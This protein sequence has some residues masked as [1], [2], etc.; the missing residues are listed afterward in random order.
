M[1]NWPAAVSTVG[2]AGIECLHDVRNGGNRLASDLKF[3]QIK[4]DHHQ[5]PL[6]EESQMA[7]GDIS[8]IRSIFEQDAPFSSRQVPTRQHGAAGPKHVA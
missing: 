3:V 4:R 2:I 5:R 6:P 8:G 1:L 7:G